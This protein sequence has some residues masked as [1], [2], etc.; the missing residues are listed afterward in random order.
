MAD[1]PIS[2]L[3]QVS[4]PPFSSAFTNPSTGAMLEILDTTNTNMA[5]TG[6]N[7]KIAPGDLLAGYL[8]AGSNVTLTETAGIVT[9]AAAAG[10][11][12]GATNGQVLTEVSGAPAWANPVTQSNYSIV[13]SSDYTSVSMSSLANITNFY[14]TINTAGTYYIIATLRAGISGNGSI[15]NQFWISG[16]LYDITNSIIV[17]NSNA[18]ICLGTLQVASTT[19]GFQGLGSI[20][21]FIYTP[22]TVPATIYVQAGSFSSGGTISGPEIFS[23]INGYSSLTAMRIY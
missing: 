3:T 1:E 6:T 18:I 8:A 16:A 20:G 22:S 12:G 15:G 5:S 14:I 9:I 17:P 21:P 23:D 11:P 4:V 2:A 13:L 10:L 19:I 7:S